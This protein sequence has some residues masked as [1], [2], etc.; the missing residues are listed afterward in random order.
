MI[1]RVFS[2][3]HSSPQIS[4]R[5]I[6]C[7]A[8]RLAVKEDGDALYS[9]SEELQEDPKLKKIAERDRHNGSF[10]GRTSPTR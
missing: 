4:V 8:K 10:K 7:S 3:Q 6:C 9:A 2:E 5:F 1:I